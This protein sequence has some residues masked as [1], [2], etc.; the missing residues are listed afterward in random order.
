MRFRIEPDIFQQFTDLRVGALSA[1]EVDNHGEP[2]E[3]KALLRH[4]E[5]RLVTSFQGTAVT[6]HPRIA[7]WRHAYRKFGAKPKKYPSSVENLARRTL[8]GERIRHINK[9]VDIYNAVSLR[10]LV[11]A[12]GEDLDRIRG[13]IV[14]AFAGEEETPVQMLGEPEKR[15]PRP[16]EVIYRDQAGAICRRWNWKEADRTKLTEDTVNAV[17]V[18]E[19]LPPVTNQELETALNE[20][21]ELI[22][23]YCGGE[24]SPTIVSEDHREVDI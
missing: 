22:G 21:A 24:T 7:P 4:A 10:H 14:L 5:E 2:S 11:P 6:E 20:L 9:L 16:G 1:R 8:K 15:A 13:D 17:L 12:G 23:R 3:V 18:I 19:A